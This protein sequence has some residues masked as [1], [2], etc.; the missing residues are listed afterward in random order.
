MKRVR[1][2]LSFGV[3]LMIGELIDKSYWDFRQVVIGKVFTTSELAYFNRGGQLPMMIST[4]LSTGLGDILFPAMSA[5]Q[6]DVERVR[7]WI[8]RV[9]QIH[10]YL[11]YPIMFG[12]AA[13]ARPLVIVLFTDKW[14]EIVPYLQLFC[15]LYIFDGIGTANTNAIKAMGYSNLIFRLN[16][17]RTPMHIVGMIVAIPFGIYAVAVSAV[18]TTLLGALMSVMLSTRIVNYPL[19]QQIKVVLPHLLLSMVM[20]LCVYPISYIG[21]NSIYILVIQVCTGALLYLF[22]SLVFKVEI[23][24]YL[25]NTAKEIIGR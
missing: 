12:M 3:N 7:F 5:I 4:T 16:L 11:F 25:K 15:M 24:F 18:V 22:A 23:F 10:S 6:D 19:G 14:I 2:L 8:K 13:V 17:I 20:A 21:I 9:I 1:T